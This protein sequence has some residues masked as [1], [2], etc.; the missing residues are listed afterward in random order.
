MERWKIYGA[1]HRPFATL[2]LIHLADIP[3][4][5][6]KE[7]AGQARWIIS[8]LEQDGAI[9]Q[10][11]DPIRWIRV[12][13]TLVLS[14]RDLETPDGFVLNIGG[15][16]DSVLKT[17]LVGLSSSARKGFPGWCSMLGRDPR[18]ALRANF[19]KSMRLGWGIR[20]EERFRGQQTWAFFCPEHKEAWNRWINGEG[21]EPD[22]RNGG[23]E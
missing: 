19:L 23:W 12:L 13:S 7:A 16:W 20:G 2:E 18:Y 3:P 14:P 22:P 1:K 9:G 21:P 5:V 6:R 15:S 17:I 10:G 11:L 8:R 4:I